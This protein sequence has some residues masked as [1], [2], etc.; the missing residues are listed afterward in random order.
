[1]PKSLVS[2][3]A[4]D[5]FFYISSAHL[6][7][8]DETTHPC[9]PGMRSRIHTFRTFRLQ[10]ILCKSRCFLHG[11]AEDI[12]TRNW[13]RRTRGALTPRSFP[14]FGGRVWPP[15]GLDLD[16]AQHIHAREI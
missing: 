16:C 4:A 10:R 9:G 5:L 8:S 1:M 3:M 15:P 13:T 12:E 7:S 6:Q 14:E 2:E 11:G